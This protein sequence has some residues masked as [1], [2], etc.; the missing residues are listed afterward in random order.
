VS[1]WRDFLAEW[2]ARRAGARY[3]PR[4]IQRSA[5]DVIGPTGDLL[6]SAWDR[7]EESGEAYIES[8][9][10]RIPPSI[11]V[12]ERDKKRHNRPIPLPE[13]RIEAHGIDDE[14]TDEER[15]WG[16]QPPQE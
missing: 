11:F 2:K 6:S 3:V 13:R 15:A 4:N 16:S 5:R 12:S 1:R 8:F 14:L 9:D 10:R 7:L